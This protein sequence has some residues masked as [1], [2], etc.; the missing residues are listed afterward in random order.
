MRRTSLLAARISPALLS[1]LVPAALIACS[2]SPATPSGHTTQT[3]ATSTDGGAPRP[4][5]DAGVSSV[6]AS[7]ADQ[8]AATT[9]ADASDDAPG[10]STSDAASDAASTASGFDA[11]AADASADAGGIDG[12]ADDAAA[13]DASTGDAQAPTGQWVLGY[14]AA[15]A[16]ASYPIDQIDWSALTHIAFGALT[17]NADQSLNTSFSDGANGVTDAKAMS[18]AAHAHNVHP[19]L[20]LGGANAGANIAT[21]AAPANRAAFVTNL[22]STMSSLGYDGFDL[23]WEDSVNLDDL[24]SLAQAL[25]AAKP[26]ILLSYPGGPINGNIQTVDAR[27]VTLAQSLDRYNIQSYFPGSVVAGYQW[28]SW[29]SSPLSGV[30]SATPIAIDDSLD[31]LAKAGI[32]KAKLGMGMAFY[33]ICYTGGITGPR[34]PTTSSNAI[35]GGDNAYPLNQFFNAGGVYDKFV[36]SRM[37]DTTAQVPYMSLPTAIDDG[38]CGAPTQYI[39]FDD[40]TSIIAKG[41]FSKAN[42]YGGIMVWTLNEGGLLPANASGGRAPNALTQALKTGF[43]DP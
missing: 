24:V 21:A 31:R 13:P 27:Q 3:Q 18:A 7:T 29:F 15:Y 14:Y 19:L 36:S 37:R 23:D 10:P 35:V 12:S 40:E 33:A 28:N 30:T 41:T 17:V 1:I 38:H 8:D 5:G 42:G 6:D 2:T 20:M 4:D 22:L 16:A 43:L 34:Q 11:S 26:D 9:A 39:A 32:P 25:R